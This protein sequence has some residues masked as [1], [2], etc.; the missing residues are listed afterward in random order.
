MYTRLYF[1]RDAGNQGGSPGFVLCQYPTVFICVELRLL[2]AATYIYIYIYIYIYMQMLS[3]KLRLAPCV[4]LRCHPMTPRTSP[5]S[6]RP[7]TVTRPTS[8]ARTVSAFTAQLPALTGP[9]RCRAPCPTTALIQSAWLCPEVRHVRDFSRT[10]L[11]Q[12][13]SH[14]LAGTPS[15]ITPVHD[16]N[17]V[18]PAMR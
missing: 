18:S 1:I 11:Q 2:A 17:S 15:G 8:S 14:Y 3:N 16:A 6:S 5:I 9:C 10:T 12:Y 4:R 13:Q 7:T